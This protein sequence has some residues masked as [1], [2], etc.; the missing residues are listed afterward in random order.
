MNNLFWTDPSSLNDHSIWDSS[1]LG[2]DLKYSVQFQLIPF[3]L[4]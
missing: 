3:T 2:F 4:Y 1:L